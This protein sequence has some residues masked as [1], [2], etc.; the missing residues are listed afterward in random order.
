MPY[1]RKTS[2]IFISPEFEAVLVQMTTSE[3]AR[4]LLKQ[5]HPV[6]TL[7]DNHVN[8]IGVSSADRTK[9]SYL[10]KD[11]FDTEDVWRTSK[12]I[13]AKPGSFIRKIF[14]DIS[15]KEVELF[16]ILYRNI[17]S[18]PVFQFKVVQ[19]E[20]VRKWYH[21]HNYYDQS[22]SLGNSCMKHSSCQ[23]YMDI[24]VQ[25]PNQVKMLCMMNGGL[26]VGRALMWHGMTDGEKT[27]DVLDRIYTINDE[28]YLYHFRKYAD[29]NGFIYK[30]EQ[31]WNNT[32]FFLSKGQESLIR[33]HIK[34]DHSDF[35][36]YPYMD[37]FKF[38]DRTTNTIY[39]HIPEN[40]DI[41]TISGGEGHYQPHDFLR[42]DGLNHTYWYPHEMVYIKDRKIW[43]VCNG[44]VYSEIYDAHI[45]RTDAVYHDELRDWIYVDPN[46]NE[47]EMIRTTVERKKTEDAIRQK[48]FDSIR[49]RWWTHQP[50]DAVE[51]ALGYFDN[52]I[53]A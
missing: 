35:A 37:T 2:D 14:K 47:W 32:M 49:N 21:H 11:R 16:S 10:T 30:K 5:R 17:Q 36:T 13:Y 34:L 22:S 29:D 7:V 18:V 50:A 4:L 27:Y 41:I 3:V 19:G 23:K 8:Y 39:N 6:E 44:V 48:K 20:D 9:I 25:N 43:T 26:L 15:D 33:G 1:I 28:E 46:L 38:L 42:E 12:R 53:T 45:L 24:Y 52:L 31:K 51:S 40:V